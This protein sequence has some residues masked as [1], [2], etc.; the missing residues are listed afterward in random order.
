MLA[1]A[2]VIRLE[3][4]AVVLLDQTRLPGERV[5]RR[6]TTVG[7]LCAAIREL[8]IK[9]DYQLRNRKLGLDERQVNFGLGF[10]Y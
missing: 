1:P 6:C 3:S 5:D 2:D 9:A 8:A 7:E 4:D 10:M